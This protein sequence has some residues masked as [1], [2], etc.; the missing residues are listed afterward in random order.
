MYKI[1]V[2]ATSGHFLQFCCSVYL[3]KCY[4]VLFCC[5]FFIMFIMSSYT[6]PVYYTFKNIFLLSFPVFWMQCSIFVKLKIMLLEFLLIS[7][8]N[9]YAVEFSEIGTQS[10]YHFFQI[11]LYFLFWNKLIE[12]CKEKTNTHFSSNPFGS[13]LPVPSFKYVS[14]HFLRIKNK[15][16]KI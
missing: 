5:V 12:D 2:H 15:N 16:K 7:Q 8:M 3:E 9:F 4:I 10:T 1:H 6:S 13:K 14:V 11:I